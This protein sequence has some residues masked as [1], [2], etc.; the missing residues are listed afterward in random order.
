VTSAIRWSERALAGGTFAGIDA[1][2][3][4]TKRETTP[5]V[6]VRGDRGARVDRALAACVAN[7]AVWACGNHLAIMK[8]TLSESA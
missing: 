3:T 1:L 7:K 4:R 5:R 6:L 2:E 8:R